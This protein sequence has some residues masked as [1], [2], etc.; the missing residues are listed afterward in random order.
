[1]SRQKRY[2]NGVRGKWD[3]TAPAGGQCDLFAFLQRFDEASALL[4]NHVPARELAIRIDLRRGGY[5][6]YETARGA[7]AGA[8][9]A[10]STPLSTFVCI[11]TTAAVSSGLLYV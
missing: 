9:L 1:M 11:H 10:P 6:A 5:K 3:H 8:R 7:R 4:R 2:L